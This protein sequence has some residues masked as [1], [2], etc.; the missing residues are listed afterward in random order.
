VLTPD[1]ASSQFSVLRTVGINM[2]AL[3]SDVV[4]TDSN[5]ER[6]P[7]LSEYVSIRQ[8]RLRI[9]FPSGLNCCLPCLAH[10]ASCSLCFL[11][12]LAPALDFALSSIHSNPPKFPL[13]PS[14]HASSRI[15]RICCLERK[16]CPAEP[17]RID[18]CRRREV[19]LPVARFS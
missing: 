5:S 6:D 1:S 11:S 13:H 12:S 17:P 10:V 15:Q 14:R 8:D 9:C 7:I 2:S 3:R 18:L 16:S 19:L 4:A